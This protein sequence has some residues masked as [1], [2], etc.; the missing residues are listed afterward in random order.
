MR[1]VALA[2]GVGG[3]KLADGLSQNLAADELTV[4][5][6]VG[7]DFNHMGLRICPDL[8]TVCYTLGGLANPDTGW[9]RSN[10]TWTVYDQIVKLGGPD[11]FH[12][13]DNDIAT[14]LE[15]TRLLAE[16]IPLSEIV[17]EFCRKW[18]IKVRVL[19]VSNDQIPTMVATKDQGEL[20][21]QDYFVRNRCEPT[22]TGFRFA[23]VSEARLAPG[24]EK[25]VLEADG[26]IICPSN[27][28]VS[29]APILTVP[30]MMDLVMKKKVVAVSPIIGGKALKGPAAKMFNEMGI[31]ASSLAVARHYQD[32][33]SGFVLD[34]I[35]VQ[36]AEE[37]QR[38]GIISLTTNTIMQSIE[39]RKRLAAEVLSFC[40]DIFFK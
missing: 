14:H 35:D 3:A 6:N 33:L 23:G 26:I 38:S 21:F 40:E 18:G 30:G 1:I 15:R 36:Y 32:F 31:E 9:G 11:W 7:D 24:V 19:P 16:G 2:G 34:D 28:Y 10:E 29:I 39:D 22:V 4:I 13:G 27:P 5:V 20:G 8:D 12:L 25:A 17:H 37:I